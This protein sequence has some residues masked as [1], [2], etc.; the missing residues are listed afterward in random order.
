M[1]N[2]PRFRPG[3]LV[4]LHSEPGGPV[5]GTYEVW[6]VGFLPW[7]VYW[8]KG[9]PGCVAEEALSPAGPAPEPI[10]EI[11][12]S[13]AGNYYGNAVLGT[14]GESYYLS[15]TNYNGDCWQPVS[16]DFA[17]AWLKEFGSDE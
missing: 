15:V 4:N 11:S 14:D 5:T 9:R 13:P 6:E 16:A 3:D 10:R 1:P 8:L 7:P 17:A 12:A 2:N